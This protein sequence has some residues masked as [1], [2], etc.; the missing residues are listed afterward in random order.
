MVKKGQKLF[1][2]HQEDQLARTKNSHSESAM[3]SRKHPDAPQEIAPTRIDTR[4]VKTIFH[5]HNFLPDK[6]RGGCC[7]ANYM[8]MTYEQDE[9]N[10]GRT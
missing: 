3:S 10:F 1:E 4:L 6:I 8:M 7:K 9:T 2:G 5:H